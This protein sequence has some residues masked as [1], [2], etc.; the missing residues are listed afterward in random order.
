MADQV[1]TREAVAANFRK[2]SL[3]RVQLAWGT[4][5][6]GQVSIA[7]AIAV[8]AYEVGGATEVSLVY[9]VRLVPAAVA[10]PF[11]A[12]LGDRFSRARVMLVSNAS[13]FALSAAIVVAAI[14]GVNHWIVYVL[15]IGIAVAGTAF[16]PAQVA[17]FP[18]L[19]ERPE[20]LTAANVV[21]STVEGLGYFLGPAIAGVL[22]AATGVTEV[23]T[24]VAVVFGLSTVFL[25]R[26]LPGVEVNRDQGDQPDESAVEAVLAGAR[27]IVRSADLRVLV[28]LF[29][30]QTLVAGALAVLLVV[31]AIELLHTGNAGVGWL[32]AAVGVGGVIGSLAAVRL[33]GRRRLTQP[34]LIGI[35]LWGAPFLLIAASPTLVSAILAFALIGVGNILVDVAGYTLL[36]RAVDDGVIAR[37]FGAVQALYF[38]SVAVGAL[39]IP[40]LVSGIGSRWTLVVTGL[41]LPVLAVAAG[42]RLLRVDRAAVAPAHAVA[43]LRDLPLFSPLPALALEQVA[44]H[45]HALSLPAGGELIRQ[46]DIG[47]RYY[48]LASGAADVVIDGEL[49]NRLGPGEGFGE[50]ALL[51]DVPRTATVTATEPTE[52]FALDR[53]TFLAAVSSNRRSFAAADET[54]SRR[55]GAM[56]GTI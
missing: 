20:E 48:V 39:L 16:R 34:F 29:T 52:V 3:R 50:I 33:A 24:F 17:I 30:A 11:A 15:S 9:V 22:L 2:P 47:D 23:F 43:L 1:G 12:V 41:F 25:V 21:A 55:L 45:L 51:R 6:L 13:R 28:G 49:V 26:P 46:G 27:A 35:V 42:P 5:L 36:Q 31:T 19:V 32:D 54:A 56:S 37:V 14:A 7:V 38:I 40:P 4:S 10:T 53:E 8:Y 18:S 44:F